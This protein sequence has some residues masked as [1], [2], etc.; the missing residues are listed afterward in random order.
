LHRSWLPR[1]RTQ[2]PSEAISDAL[3]NSENNAFPGFFQDDTP[4]RAV[5]YHK[6]PQA[7]DWG[8]SVFAG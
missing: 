6:K 1:T 4:L 5:S 8:I 7:S 3:L 2:P